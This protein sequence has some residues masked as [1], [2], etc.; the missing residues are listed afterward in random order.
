[1]GKQTP[2]EKEEAFFRHVEGQ[3]S[4]RQ[5]MHLT[6]VGLWL[7]TV[8]PVDAIVNEEGGRLDMEKEYPLF[9]AVFLLT[10]T[11]EELLLQRRL[12]DW[13]FV[14]RRKPTWNLYLTPKGS[15]L[16]LWLMLAMEER[17]FT[18]ERVEPGAYYRHIDPKRTALREQAMIKRH[19]AAELRRL[20]EQPTPQ[21]WRPSQT[22]PT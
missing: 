15:R 16:I 9:A 22:S 18:H 8:N 5:V 13:G 3:L 12:V 20:Q 10:A 21:Q 19:E 17:G 6:E 11:L 2:R 7:K 1:M 4:F 14:K